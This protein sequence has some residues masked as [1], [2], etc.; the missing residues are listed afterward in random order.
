MLSTTI[1][2]ATRRPRPWQLWCALALLL[3]LASG[4]AQAVPAY[5]RQTG[6]SCSDCHAAAYGGGPGGPMLTPYGLRFKMG[7]YT[8]TDGNGTKIPLSVQL[9]ETHSAPAKGDS[10]TNLSEGD[11][12]LAGRVSDNV[13]GFVKVEADHTGHNTYNTVLR[14]VDLRFVAKELKLA[15]KELLLG[16][17][18]NNMP[19]FDDPLNALSA[20]NTISPAGVTGTLLNFS[21]ANAPAS[22][23]IGA[24]VY[25]LFDTNWY[26]EVGTYKSMPTSLQDHLGYNVA[27]DPGK[28][29]D[30]GYFR[31][32][33]MKDMKSQY[34]SAGLVGLTTKRELPRNGGPKDDITDLGYDVSYQYLGNRQHIVQLSYSNILEKRK[35]GS[36]FASPT[37][38]TLFSRSRGNV[39]DQ[40]LTATYVFKQSYGVTVA[41]LLST[42][43]PDPVRY[44][45]NG[46]PDTT[47]NLI[48]VFWV[49]F[50][51]DDSYIRWGNL[52]LSATWFRFTKFNGA[53]SNIFAAPV[54]APKTNPG[55]FNA[56]SVA[57][58][59]AF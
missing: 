37:D 33:Y 12:Y 45:P 58:S 50:G 42:G 49:P 53:T 30:T 34:F 56:F 54:G 2:R 57:A 1:H 29:S 8:D 24:T 35:Y 36:T 9:T 52:K 31:F 5:A 16:V 25:A 4:G 27:G 19:G 51:K 43:S 44:T 13:G 18:V 15:G 47:A 22:R 11:L 21:S 20:S 6:S 46:D 28:L 26:G 10:T 55:D 7:G 48:S 14:N 40:T 3:L 17:S 39:H 59:V 38:P 32:A 41:H 23:V